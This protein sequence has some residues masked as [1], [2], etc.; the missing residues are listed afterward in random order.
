MSISEFLM[1]RPESMQRSSMLGP[2]QQSLYRQM[3]GA[4]MGA[5]PQASQYYRS[6]LDPS[7]D[8]FQAFAAPQMR[9]FRQQILPQIGARYAGMGAGAQNSSGY[10]NAMMQAG[11]DLSERLAAM[12]A[13]L[14]QQGAQGLMG[15][16]GQGLQQYSM[17][18]LRPRT[19]GFLEQIAGGVSQLGSTALGVPMGNYLN[20][21][22][23]Q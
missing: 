16:A 13:G 1:G 19:P 18:Y 9:Q 10:R 11:T 5:A 2:E 3:L 23:N 21:M 4:G 6:L 14:Q 15:L 22:L 17:P 8:A 7:S 12:R 20:R